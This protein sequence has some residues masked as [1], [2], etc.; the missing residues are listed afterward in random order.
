MLAGARVIKV[1]STRRPDGA[2]TGPAAFFDLL[3][4]DKEM[5]SLDAGDPIDLRRLRRLLGAADLVLEASRPRVMEQWGVDPEA[6][7]A[8]GTSWISITGHGRSGPESNRVAFGDDAAVAGGLVVA[9][10]PPRFVADAIADE[11]MNL[12]LVTQWM[13][14]KLIPFQTAEDALTHAR[15]QS[16]YTKFTEGR[17]TGWIK[18]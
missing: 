14:E 2:R 5:M 13:L 16:K 11:N 7:V 3:N 17:E 8:E 1:E 18:L 10:A 4:A 12:M 6:L 15:N 9:G